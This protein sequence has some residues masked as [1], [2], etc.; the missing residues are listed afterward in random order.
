[1]AKR[2]KNYKKVAEEI[3]STKSY[4]LEEAVTLALKGDFTKFDESVDNLLRLDSI[5]SRYGVPSHGGSQ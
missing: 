4:S 1:M 3:D 5:R 2:G